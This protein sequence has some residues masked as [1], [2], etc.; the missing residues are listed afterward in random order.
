MNDKT[1]VETFNELVK[2]DLEFMNTSP[3]DS[4]DACYIYD[5][6]MCI[7]GNLAVIADML[8]AKEDRIKEQEFKKR[9]YG[10]GARETT[11][12]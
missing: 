1:M 7:A 10:G 3:F 11:V 12:W 2:R 8:K 4:N 6:L 9:H 5:V